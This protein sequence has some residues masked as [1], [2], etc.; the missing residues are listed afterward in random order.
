MIVIGT[1]ADVVNY[2]SRQSTIL[3]VANLLDSI[4]HRE[5]AVHL[6]PFYPTSGDGGFAIDDWFHI[7]PDLGTWEDV[8]DLAS[9][10]RLIVDG[11]YNHV[12]MGHPWVRSFFREPASNTDRLFA[13]RDVDGS[14]LLSPRGQPVLKRYDINGEP[15]YLW[16]TF[17]DRAVDIRL[18]DADVITEIRRHLKLL[19][20]HGIWGIRLDAVAYYAKEL[21]G[22]I[23]HNPGAFGLATAIADLAEAEDLAVLAQIDCDDDGLRYFTASRQSHYVMSDFTFSSR[24]ALSMLSHDPEP[25]AQHLRMIAD[26]PHPCVRGPR[27]H[28]GLLLRSGLLRDTDVERIVSFTRKLDLPLRMSDGEPYELNCSAPY[29][30]ECA[31]TREDVPDIIDL[32]LAVSGIVPG[33]CYI[34]LPLLMGFIPETL[35]TLPIDPRALNRTPI[36]IQVVTDY[37]GSAIAKRR[38]RLL[39]VLVE[40]HDDPLFVS[41]SGVAQANVVDDGLLYIA[42]AAGR[43]TLIANFG[44]SECRMVPPEPSRELIYGSRYH[45][46]VLGP[47][48]FALWRS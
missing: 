29:L 46:E 48:G 32:A 28:D 30:Y 23:R 10:R 6:L 37:I 24:L 17:T 34:Y 47:F 14:I 19:R 39:D 35:S 7:R 4:A 45:D 9:R 1:Y 43:Y 38:L 3:E 40:M 20:L 33:W 8:A 36:P 21:H 31:G 27:T 22:S 16:Q 25:L 26:V 5:V 44:I 41:E 12:G 2:G 13:Y 15:W 11:V 18:D 42:V